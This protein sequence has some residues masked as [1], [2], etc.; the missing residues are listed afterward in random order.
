MKSM[1]CTATSGCTS[2]RV[3]AHSPAMT[4][5][6]TPAAGVMVGIEAARKSWVGSEV[7]QTSA[8]WL[9]GGFSQ[10][11]IMPQAAPS[12]GQPRPISRLG[13]AGRPC[14]AHMRKHE[15]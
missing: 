3:P 10:R 14:W 11:Q 8:S 7:A 1:Y 2:A 15:S 5:A 12:S 9:S 6:V 4:L 13:R